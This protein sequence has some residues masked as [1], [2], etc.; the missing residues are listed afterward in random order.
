MKAPT[1]KEVLN[2]M[3][4]RPLKAEN[5]GSGHFIQ[6]TYEWEEEKWTPLIFCGLRWQCIQVGVESEPK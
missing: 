3:E 2:K 5:V 4:W 1:P 6:A